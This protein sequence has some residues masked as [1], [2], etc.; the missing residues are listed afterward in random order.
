[1]GRHTGILY[2][3]RWLATDSPQKQTNLFHSQ[4]LW[5]A[6]SKQNDLDASFE[7]HW[8]QAVSFIRSVHR[9]KEAY[10]AGWRCAYLECSFE[11]YS[12]EGSGRKRSE[13][14]KLL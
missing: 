3:G 2:P 10:V 14:N 4:S 6:N 12:T 5:S 1:M 13:T 11:I 8:V 7:A 9:D